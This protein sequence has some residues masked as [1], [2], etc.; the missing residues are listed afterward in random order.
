[1]TYED[2]FLENEFFI[3]SPNSYPGDY[4]T[5][6]ILL[7]D[8]DEEYN[9]TYDNTNLN[10]SFSYK[11]K[12]EENSLYRSL[13]KISKKKENNTNVDIKNNLD[14]SYKDEKEE[15]GKNIEFLQGR[16]ENLEINIF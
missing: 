13:T 7:Q 12:K 4:S 14:P 2:T 15:K 5:S 16:N 10:N 6:N 9:N 11:T 1:M 8:F 3:P